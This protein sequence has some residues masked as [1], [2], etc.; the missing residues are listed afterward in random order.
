[1]LKTRHS[2]AKEKRSSARK[3]SESQFCRRVS[4]NEDAILNV[5]NTD[6]LEQSI[7]VKVV[8]LWPSSKP[9][10]RVPDQKENIALPKKIALRNWQV[11]GNAIL[12]HS[13][14]RQYILKALICGVS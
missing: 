12:K 2:P 5:D 8:M 7:C 11:V 6:S 4:E 10:L 13:E 14:L 3:L 9:D 1:M